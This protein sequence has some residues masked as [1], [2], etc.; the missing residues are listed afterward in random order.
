MDMFVLN[1]ILAVLEVF[2]ERQLSLWYPT[3]SVTTQWGFFLL[4]LVVLWP[5][6]HLLFAKLTLYYWKIAVGV[7]ANDIILNLF[8]S[9]CAFLLGF[10]Q[11]PIF[12]VLLSFLACQMLHWC[13]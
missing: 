13:P 12:L 10:T 6:Y 3:Q 5:F 9:T 1:P 7:V 8:V 4:N 2:L 11:R